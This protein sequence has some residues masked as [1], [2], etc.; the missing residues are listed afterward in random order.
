MSRFVLITRHPSDC[1]E[2][3]AL[4]SPSGIT[5][6]PYP[7]LRLEDVGDDEGWDEIRRSVG[8]GDQPRWLV[9][10]SPR[11]PERFV[12]FAV[13]HDLEELTTVPAAAIGR[14][15]RGLRLWQGPAPGAAN[16]SR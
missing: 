16:N 5:L 14:A 15:D 7:V 11:A 10:A 2:L 1:A 9:L 12:R 6:R 3:Q 8:D 4:L 13:E